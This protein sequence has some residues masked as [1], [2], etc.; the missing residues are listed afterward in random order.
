MENNTKQVV[1]RFAP[2]PTGML[3][4][5]GART[6]LYNWLWAR[7]NNGKFVLRIED[8]DQERFVE[9]AEENIYEGLKWLGME[10]DEGPFKQ[11]ERT[12]IYKKYADQLVEQGKAYYCFCTK[13]RLDEMREIQKKMNKAPKYDGLC[14]NL[15]KEEIEE[16]IKAGEKYV[17]RLKLPQEGSVVVDDMVRGKVKFEYKD[18]D[19]QVLVKSDGFPTYHLAN[20]VDDHDM[21]INH[22]IRGEEWLPST[23]KHIYLYEALGWEPPRWAHLSL[24]IKK[25]GGK[26]SK[27]E[28]ATSLLNYKEMGYL[29]EAVNNFIAFLG[30]NPKDE[31]ELFTLEELAKEFDLKNVNKANPIFDTDKLDYLNG[32]YLRKKSLDELYELAKPYL[33]VE[34][35]EEY[36]KKVLGLE[37]ERIK[38][39]SEIGEMTEYFFT[40]DLKYDSELLVWKKSTPA[41]TKENLGLLIKKLEETED[42]GK[43]SLEKNIIDWIKSIEKG[44]GDIL[45][46]MRAALTGREKSPSPF[47]VASVLGKERSLSRLQKAESML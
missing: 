3:H 45:W 32:L 6:C 37:Q 8:T 46:P 31:R 41:E 15:S 28:G 43:E 36:I 40:D 24:F 2:S 44:N 4:I 23:P 1:T 17:V 21:G 29:P 39:L 33:K 13:D 27:R 14:R 19:D 20:V 35:D 9:G 25:G 42:W 16:K 22:V 38:K 10:W 12:E 18:I 34:A 7:K 26:L 47:E 11:S 30:W 5:G